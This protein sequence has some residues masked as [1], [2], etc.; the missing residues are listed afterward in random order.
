MRR[1]HVEYERL[2]A[3][4]AAGQLSEAEVNEL[5]GH[6]AK[7]DACDRCLA[8]LER[9][10]RAYFLEYAGRTKRAALPAGMQRRF[11]ER[12]VSVGVP[13]RETTPAVPGT[14]S[15]SLA[16]SVVP[17]T[18]FAHLGWRVVCARLPGVQPETISSKALRVVPPATRSA[19][20]EGHRHRVSTVGLQA[21][22]TKRR[23]HRAGSYA[24][25][26]GAAGKV[27]SYSGVYEAAAAGLQRDP[28]G[29]VGGAPLLRFAGV[30]DASSPRFFLPAERN[31]ELSL[32]RGLF[33]KD[34]QATLDQ[35]AFRYKPALASV[36]FLG[37][38]ERVDVLRVPAMHEPPAL[39]HPDSNRT[40]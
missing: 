15:M 13:L 23:L 11:E 1:D 4:A 26:R 30:K 24:A 22:R 38:T 25:L 9:A 5:R 12:A 27:R 8:E 7:C 31:A 28:E 16:L 2:C 10:S 36:T 19:A 39:F 6:V 40:W 3:F 34:G 29:L 32:D 17:L 33:A 37:V 21:T 18:I 35:H 20:D 14:R